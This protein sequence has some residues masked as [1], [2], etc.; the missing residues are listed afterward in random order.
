MQAIP[1]FEQIAFRVILIVVCAA[2]LI[3]GPLAYRSFGEADGWA[4]L[5][6]Q[7]YSRLQAAQRSG[8]CEKTPYLTK[9]EAGFQQDL[10]KEADGFWGRAGEALSF[11]SR[12][13]L[14][15]W[16][17]PV[18]SLAAFY[19]GRWALS[20]RLTPAWPLHKQAGSDHE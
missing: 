6:R 5:A 11:A 15:A 17:V 4:S 19:I 9:C 3:F 14:L 8:D 13:R 18:T 1:R 12:M 20:G 10:Q 2:P 16:A 7:E